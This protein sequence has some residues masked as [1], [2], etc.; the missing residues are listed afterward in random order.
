MHWMRDENLALLRS[1][2]PPKARLL[3]IGCGTGEEAIQLAGQGYTVVAT[4]ISPRMVAVARNKGNE[5]SLS[6]RLSFLTRPAAG[7]VDIGSPATFDG[8]YASFGGLNCEPDLKA[9]ADALGSLL[10]PGA[11][12]VCSVMSHLCPFE[13]AWYT[14]HLRPSI[15]LRRW[16]G[17]WQKATISGRDHVRAEVPIRYLSA[18]QLTTA[19]DSYFELEKSLSLGLLLPP[20]YL[21]HLFRESSRLW[22]R[23]IILERWLRVRWPWRG[24]GDHIA[25][26]MRKKRTPHSRQVTQ[27]G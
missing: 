5:A 8:A 7:L 6:A 17:G 4:D 20:P 11:S 26:V 2:F 23:V 3:E 13:L 19:F 18:A 21:D 14:F 10:K 12:F 25:L 16:R 15:A 9:V 27:D 24:M 22:D 1:T